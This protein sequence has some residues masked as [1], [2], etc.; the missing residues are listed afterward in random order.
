MS[1]VYLILAFLLGSLFG[2]VVYALLTAASES[3]SGP[4]PDRTDTAFDL[5]P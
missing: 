4:T 5:L 1:W 3:Y 2:L